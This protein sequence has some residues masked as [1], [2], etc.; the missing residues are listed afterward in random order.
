MH[1]MS[2]SALAGI[3]AIAY[4]A[5]SNAIRPNAASKCPDVT[6]TFSIENS[7]LYPENLDWDPVNCKLYLR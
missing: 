5:P 1:S 3:L 6:G 4:A 2:L 7:R